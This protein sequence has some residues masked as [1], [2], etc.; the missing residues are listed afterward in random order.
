MTGENFASA[1]VMEGRGDVRPVS[2]GD[3]SNFVVSFYTREVED[4]KET[5]IRGRVVLKG[6]AFCRKYAVGDTKTI[7]DLPV[8]EA[9][10]MRFPSQWAAF[11][12]GESESVVGTPLEAWP[13][14]NADMRLALKNEGFKTVDQIANVSDG[15]LSTM[16]RVGA[17]IQKVRANAQQFLGD[18]EAGEAERRLAAKLEEKDNQLAAMQEQMAQLSQQMERMREMQINAPVH[19]SQSAIPSAPA[20]EAAP[21]RTPDVSVL[22]A[23][24][25]V[26]PVE[27][28]PPKRRP[29]RPRKAAA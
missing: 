22:D 10:K 7:W 19:P 5:A 2:Y 21:E 24:P 13:L 25:E 26:E 23:L 12:R 20:K 14:L 15:A 9:D 18:Q 1:T 28:E 29:G 8:T 16:G 17:L 4:E 11:E 6:I 3:D 27:E